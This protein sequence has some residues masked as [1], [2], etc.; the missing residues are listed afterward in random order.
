MKVKQKSVNFE[1]VAKKL[2]AFA[3]ETMK[4]WEKIK[5]KA[6][7]K[8]TLHG[9]CLIRASRG[10]RPSKPTQMGRIPI[11][12]NNVRTFTFVAT[13]QGKKHRANGG[14]Q[15]GIGTRVVQI[16]EAGQGRDRSPGVAD[17]AV[18][19]LVGVQESAGLARPHRHR[20]RR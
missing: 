14:I 19:V 9:R 7:K 11:D 6:N 10:L 4:Q 13:L 15:F 12:L 1:R 20:S 16:L 5:P 18:G 8:R 17:L 2:P 3:M